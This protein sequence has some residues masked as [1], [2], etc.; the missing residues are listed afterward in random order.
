MWAQT[1]AGQYFPPYD[2]NGVPISNT[3]VEYSLPLLAQGNV[4][5]NYGI[6]FLGLPGLASLIP[7]LAAVVLVY[8]LI[9]RLVDGRIPSAIPRI[10]RVARE[11]N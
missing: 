6:I 4:A 9:P 7:L 1:I 2:I 10:V 8:L 11:N 3:L 5:R